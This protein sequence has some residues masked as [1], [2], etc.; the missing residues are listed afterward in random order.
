MNGVCDFFFFFYK[1]CNTLTEYTRIVCTVYRFTYKKKY[2]YI[3]ETN[4]LNDKPVLL[5]NCNGEQ[6]KRGKKI[7]FD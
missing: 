4:I 6:S 7:A 2:I 3:L 5:L 1:S